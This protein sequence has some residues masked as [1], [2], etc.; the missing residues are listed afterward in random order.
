MPKKPKKKPSEMSDRE[1]LRAVFPERVVRRVE[2]ELEPLRESPEV[3]MPES[4]IPNNQS[5]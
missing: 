5:L 4:E 1:L 3:P 2:E